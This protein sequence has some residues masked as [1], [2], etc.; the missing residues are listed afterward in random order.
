MELW[1]IF[2]FLVGFFVLAA[3]WG[4]VSKWRAEKE[5]GQKDGSGDGEN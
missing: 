5:D 4:A 3:F 2:A 1:R